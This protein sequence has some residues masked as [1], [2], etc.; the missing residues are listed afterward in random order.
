MKS[1]QKNSLSLVAVPVLLFLSLGLIACSP[2]SE[3]PAGSTA[4]VD[5]TARVSFSANFSG[6]GQAAK[7]IIGAD[8][9]S[10]I[11]EVAA[12]VNGTPGTPQILPELSPSSPQTSTSLVPGDYVFTA[13]ALDVADV[14]IATTKTG[15]TLL[16]GDNTVVMTFLNG[17]WT[18]QDAA[19]NDTPTH[20]NTG[21][22]LDGFRLSA[23]A[24]GGEAMPAK[25]ADF[26]NF[27]GYAY[28][29]FDWT[30]SPALTESAGLSQT[31]QFS[32][33]TAADANSSSLMGGFYNLTQQCISGYCEQEVGDTQ[34]MLLGGELEDL[35]DY[36]DPFL[37]DDTLDPNID[38][39][40]YATS[41]VA[42][43]STITG[44]LLELN[45][46]SES[47]S[48]VQ[49]AATSA[50][51][52]TA[53][54]LPLGSAKGLLLALSSALNT[55]S[56]TAAQSP[57]TA[58]ESLA[59]TYYEY[60]VCGPTGGDT[61]DW[62]FS[63]SVIVEDG[64]TTCYNSGYLGTSISPNLGQ[65]SWGIEQTGGDEGE[66]QMDTVASPY[67]CY[68]QNGDGVIDTGTYQL[69]HYLEYSE[70]LNVYIYPIIAK[71]VPAP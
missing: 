16:T 46:L 45:L 50:S 63:G 61:G 36:V 6:D 62:V 4:E 5:K 22:V 35:E 59:S 58:F 53:K 15:G 14:E 40:Q 38:I 57:N 66:C 19:G 26:S 7:A 56:K 31:S 65:Y 48:F 70:Q 23:Y 52:T 71:G 12:L 30:A 64:V 32:G 27:G 47:V 28:Y 20:L 24:F 18:F 39:E 44:N 42:D 29:A 55:V 1:M 17:L 41:T 43:A 13:R 25:A 33:G 69:T 49:V 34:I 37:P 3:A 21:Q 54:G 51:K 60:A 68:D 9:A 8:V 67:S 2:S 11:I 10:I